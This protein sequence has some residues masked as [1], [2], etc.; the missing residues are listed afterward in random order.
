MSNTN[1]SNWDN[2]CDTMSLSIEETPIEKTGV[3]WHCRANSYFRYLTLSEKPASYPILWLNTVEHFPGVRT[4]T[5][6]IDPQNSSESIHQANKISIRKKI[7]NKLENISSIEKAKNKILQSFGRRS[8]QEINEENSFNVSVYIEL[9]AG[10]KENLDRC[11][12]LV[13]NAADEMD[14]V[15][16]PIQ[17]RHVQAFQ[18]CAPTGSNPLS[19]NQR[20]NDEATATTAGFGLYNV[21]REEQGTNQNN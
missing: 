13:I 3:D 11:T 19:I 18:C 6:H 10:S 14:I 20:M 1:L 7:K 12:E 4:V 9:C 16:E 8:A 15:L 21:T 5:A 17:H 2:I